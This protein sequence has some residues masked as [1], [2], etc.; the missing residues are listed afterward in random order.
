MT[1]KNIQSNRPLFILAGNGPYD[2]RGCEAI[3]RGTVKILRSY[4]N[5]PEFLV[6]SHY[7][8]DDQFKNQK[9]K[10]P[11]RD[12]LH[13]KVLRLYN[14]LPS[15]FLQKIGLSLLPHQLRSGIVYQELI[16]YLRHCK[17]VLAVGGDNYSLNYGKPTLFTDL[18]NLVLSAKKPIIIWG[19]SI[20][21]F[22]QIPRYERYMKKHLKRISGIFARESATIEYLARIGI[23][24]NVYRV[25]DPAFLLEP[26]QPSPSKFDNQISE[27]AI[28][29]NLSPLM[30]EYT[31]SG[32]LRK[33]VK[34]SA[35]IIKELLKKIK[36]PIFLIP[37]V[38]SPQTDDYDFLKKVSFLVKGGQKIFLA[39][40]DLTA[41]E[42]KWLISKTFVF[43][44][45]RTHSVISAFSSG[46]PALS[47]AYSLKAQGINRDVY[48]DE[49]FCLNFG[50]LKPSIVSTRIEEMIRRQRELKE[51][52]DSNLPKIK[53]L[54]MDA[55]KYLKDIINI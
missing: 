41:A 24:N 17:A 54:A 53:Q 42:T 27:G 9:L 13:K 34:Q 46:V 47:F 12:I 22:S 36:R 4:F 38:T 30:A 52:V 7:R 50:E 23:T 35:E 33:W 21:P 1:S 37:H 5:N 40:P 45:S 31:T 19:A 16:P 3:V 10:E 6:L 32:N 14:F 55:G 51:R 15:R 11:D 44:G 29:I 26:L 48:S 43:A 8:T 2:N 20:G 25:A 18:D 39:P 49:R 28:G